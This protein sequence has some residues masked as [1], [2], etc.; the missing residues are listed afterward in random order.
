[1]PLDSILAKIIRDSGTE[2]VTATEV[3]ILEREQNRDEL[4]NYLDRYITSNSLSTVSIA[5][6]DIRRYFRDI[7]VGDISIQPQAVLMGAN[8]RRLVALLI[9]LLQKNNLI[10]VVSNYRELLTAY[11]KAMTVRA[12]LVSHRL[13]RRDPAFQFALNTLIERRY[14][15]SFRNN[16]RELQQRMNTLVKSARRFEGTFTTFIIYLVEDLYVRHHLLE[17][18]VSL[19][20]GTT[21]TPQPAQLR[22]YKDFKSYNQYRQKLENERREI[23]G[24]IGQ[25]SNE[26]WHLSVERRGLRRDEVSRRDY[27]TAQINEVIKDRSEFRRRLRAINRILLREL[28]QEIPRL[29]RVMNRRV[30]GQRGRSLQDSIEIYLRIRNTI[31]QRHSERNGLLHSANEIIHLEFGDQISADKRFFLPGYTNDFLWQNYDTLVQHLLNG[32]GFF[33]LNRIKTSLFTLYGPCTQAYHYGFD[34]PFTTG[35][36]PGH[37]WSAVDV[38]TNAGQDIHVV[39]PDEFDLPAQFTVNGLGG[40]LRHVRSVVS[41]YR[42]EV[43]SN[44]QDVFAK[45][46]YGT[47]RSIHER[48]VRGEE[49]RTQ[50]EQMGRP[51]GLPNSQRFRLHQQAGEESSSVSDSP[52]PGEISV[53]VVPD[54][55]S[56]WVSIPV[57]ITDISSG[58][59][60][61]DTPPPDM[62][63]ADL[64]TEQR[65]YRL[66][67]LISQRAIEAI[68]EQPPPGFCVNVD[69]R[70]VL[71]GLAY[72]HLVEEQDIPQE[73]DELRQ[74]ILLQIENHVGRGRPLFVRREDRPE[75]IGLSGAVG[76]IGIRRL[77]HPGFRHDFAVVRSEVRRM[78]EN[79]V[80]SI[81]QQLWRLLWILRDYGASPHR[82]GQGVTI[83]HTYSL[84]NRTEIIIR[85][86]NTHFHHV[87]REMQPGTPVAR[88]DPIGRV[89]STG[90][91]FSSHNHLEITVLQSNEEI[92]ALLPHQFFPKRSPDDLL[93]LQLI[94]ATGTQ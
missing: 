65:D 32:D 40:N 21:F 57:S 93:P 44:I 64:I 69:E 61:S 86:V 60:P 73:L 33:N 31:A 52:A 80:G 27:L 70:R 23:N 88:G 59:T 36:Y 54:D 42:T 37:A 25:D 89:G 58:G 16:E 72:Y 78:I 67:S 18:M 9:F 50:M 26:I 2:H 6:P 91:A 1:M 28:N 74:A 79:N 43:S 66:V 46:A 47:M 29:R 56:G 30:A 7:H 39:Y 53:H 85:V 62:D 77:I 22:D 82:R 17:R 19:S 76:S 94:A 49:I 48:S 5:L 8:S 71:A 81:Q 83:D 13:N 4:R 11:E 20:L 15:V 87:E 3:G 75:I 84:S 45:I 63:L 55:P 24:F 12:L 68:Q 34:G 90:N 35:T 14:K 10:S 41:Q 92:G 38:N 51:A